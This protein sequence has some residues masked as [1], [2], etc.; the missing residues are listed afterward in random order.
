M[1]RKKKSSDAILLH[2]DQR[3]AGET[4]AAAVRAMR[5]ELSWSQAKRMVATRQ[6]QIDGNLCLDA[7]R[8]IKV[9]EVLK[10]FHE[11]LPR[12]P[13][14]SDVAV[15]YLDDA[16]A[17]VEKP[18]GMVSVRHAEEQNWDAR[19]KQFQP[20]LD[21]LMP[22][23]LKNHLAHVD[24]RRPAPGH[25]RP[26]DSSARH[27][28]G[29]MPARPIPS[30]TGRDVPGHA[31]RIFPVHRLDRETS[32][33]MVFGRT[34][35]SEAALIAQFSAHSIER[36]YHALVR[37]T[38]SATTVET[39]LVRDRGDGLRGS[40]SPDS[41]LAKRGQRAVTH[42]SPLKELAGYTLVRCQ[43][44]TGRTHQI[45][46]HLA[47]LGVPLC[48]E[49]K[50]SGPPGAPARRD[51]SGARRVALHAVRLGLVHPVTEQKMVFESP[52][53]A[54]LLALIGRLSSATPDRTRQQRSDTEGK[55]GN[56]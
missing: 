49:R 23:V 11:P 16:I 9:G 39:I 21:E 8:R 52:L 35:Q 32:G 42:L 44:E 37:G 10:L 47:E 18:A 19:R 56:E 28:S 43:L 24:A 36:V 48:G 30:R 7:G 40:V 54:D 2:V 3:S 26:E 6:L 4:V 1:A 34:A 20:T 13:D 41:P 51:E 27:K 33:L 45:R 31:F 55:K 14:A 50:Y 25:P 46:I 5:P 15:V 38:V 53:P 22:Q 12:L 17:I 29:K